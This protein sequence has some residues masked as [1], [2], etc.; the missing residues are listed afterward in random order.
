MAHVLA[1]IELNYSNNTI[2]AK[3]VLEQG[4]WHC[5]TS[6]QLLLA[7]ALCEQQLGN[8]NAARDI[9]ERSLNVDQRYAQAWQIFGVMEMQAWNLRTAKTL[10]EEFFH[11]WRTLAYL[12]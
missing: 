9:F 11:P 7:M 10:F 3:N 12:W 8:K 5:R 4:L 1:M 6:P 2:H